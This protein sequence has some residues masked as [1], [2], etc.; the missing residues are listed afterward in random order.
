MDND[1]KSL[2]DELDRYEH[3]KLRLVGVQRKRK[4]QRRLRHKLLP[5]GVTS[6][7]RA[8]FGWFMTKSRP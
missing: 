4:L 6:T 2:G 5:Y 3:A 8:R 7:G 1:L